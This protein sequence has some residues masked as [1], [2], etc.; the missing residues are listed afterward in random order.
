LYSSAYAVSGRRSRA[1]RMVVMIF[2][3]KPPL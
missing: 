1:E 2:F 3:M